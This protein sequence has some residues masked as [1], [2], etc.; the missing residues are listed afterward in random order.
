MGARILPRII[1]GASLLGLLDMFVDAD[2]RSL[3]DVEIN[4]PQIQRS[5]SPA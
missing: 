2:C 3:N 5:S 4:P 1:A